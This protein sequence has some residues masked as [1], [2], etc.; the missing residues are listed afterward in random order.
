MKFQKSFAL[1]LAAIICVTASFRASKARPQLPRLYKEMTQSERAAFVAEHARAVARQMSGR[2]YQFTPAFEHELQRAVDFYVRRIGNDGGDQPG[3]GDARFIFERGQSVAPTLIREFKARGVS[4]LIGLYIPLVESEYVNNSSPNSHG[5][6][7]MFQ[8][9]PQTAA[10]YGLNANELLDVE[11]SADAAARYIA[12]GMKKF[13]GDSMKEAL[14]ILAYNRGTNNVERDLTAVVTQ[15]NASCSI[16]ALT[17]ERDKLDS[18]FRNENVLYVPRFFAGAII[19]E[20]PD[21][22]GLNAQALS[23][24]GA[25][26]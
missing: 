20:N 9:L 25:K 16:C 12:D 21:T 15:E 17:A 18:T 5:A 4:P 3:K 1:M 23:S 13:S 24:L 6:L 14:A 10:R 19:G 11:K 22:F 8:F 7:G 2:D 26:P